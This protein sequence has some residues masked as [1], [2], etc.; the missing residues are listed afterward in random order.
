MRI[1]LFLF[2]L[3]LTTVFAPTAVGQEKENPNANSNIQELPTIDQEAFDVIYT[4]KEAGE[5]KIKVAPLPF[6]D[7]RVPTD[8]AGKKMIVVW[9]EQPDKKFEISWDDIERIEL[10]EQ[11]IMREIDEMV[12]AKDYAGAFRYIG[13]LYR[14]YPKTPDLDDMRK[15]LLLENGAYLF[16]QKQYEAALVV[17]ESLYR[18]DSNYEA[19]KV[20]T[21]ISRP[22]RLYHQRQNGEKRSPS[23]S[24]LD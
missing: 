16:S 3:L 4:K 14:N 23:S 21:A 22:G 9:L 2:M 17:M 5:D 10:Y 19:S 1:Q 15:K 24:T 11:I 12:A 7:R 20:S 6:P 18:G 13:F 8:Q